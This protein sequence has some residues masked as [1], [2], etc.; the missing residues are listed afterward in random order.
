M[1]HYY[2]QLVQVKKQNDT[3]QDISH[4]IILLFMQA[5]NQLLK[6]RTEQ[7]YFVPAQECTTFGGVCT[8]T[9]MNIIIQ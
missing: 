9:N 4:Y 3:I 6:P 8:C 2:Y 7:H 1:S 5:S